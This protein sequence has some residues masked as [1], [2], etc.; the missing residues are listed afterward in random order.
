MIFLLF[1]GAVAGM[2]LSGKVRDAPGLEPR[3][4]AFR[5]QTIIFLRELPKMIAL[6]TDYQQSPSKTLSLL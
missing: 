6:V 5:G 3:T 2:K 4:F 1:R